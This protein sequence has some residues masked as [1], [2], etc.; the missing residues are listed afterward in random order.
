MGFL[1]ACPQALV[2]CSLLIHPIQ[3]QPYL[4]YSL[5]SLSIQLLPFSMEEEEQ[6]GA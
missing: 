6:W 4:P 5:Y 1:T 3:L 2:T